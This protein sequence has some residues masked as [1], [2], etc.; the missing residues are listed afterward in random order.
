MKQ[1]DKFMKKYK[2]QNCMCIYH[3]KYINILYSS[4]LYFIRV[5]RVQLKCLMSYQENKIKTTKKK[6]KLNQYLKMNTFTI[7]KYTYIRIIR[8]QG[9]VRNITK[10][11]INGD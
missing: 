11:K 2:K 9:Q 10:Q 6:L 1:N 7:W 8:R 4:F 3:H 5:T